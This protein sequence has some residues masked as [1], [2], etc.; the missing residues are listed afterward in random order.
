MAGNRI[1]FLGVSSKK[2]RFD[3]AEKDLYGYSLVEEKEALAASNTG[4]PSRRDQKHCASFRPK[5][6]KIPL[7]ILETYPDIGMA[8][9]GGDYTGRFLAGKASRMDLGDGRSIVMANDEC[10]LLSSESSH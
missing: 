3:V 1:A 7:Q 6:S 10:R 4:Y 2:V 5:R 9:C 8:L